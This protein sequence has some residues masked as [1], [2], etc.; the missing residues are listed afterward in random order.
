MNEN[1]YCVYMHTNKVNGK[2]YIG[3]TR[4]N[5]K[6]RWA[7][8]QG[9]KTQP[10]YRAIEKYG[11]DSFKH[12]ILY[13]EL[14]YKSACEYEINLIK[15]Y[16]TTDSKYGYNVSDGGED[17]IRYYNNL[18]H[19]NKTVYQY[20]FFGYYIQKF[21]S[22]IEAVKY[23]NIENIH[24]STNISSC[25]RKNGKSKSA[26][27]FIWSY[28][29][30]GEKINEYNLKDAYG[31][32][33]RIK[34]YQYGLDGKYI[35]MFE[36]INSVANT[37]NVKQQSISAAIDL[38]HR[39]SCGFQWRTYLKEEGIEPYTKNPDRGNKLKKKIVRISKYD[40][41]VTIY[42]GIVDAKIEMN[43]QDTSVISDVLNKNRPSAYGYFWFYYSEYESGEWQNQIDYTRMQRPIYVY[44]KQYNEFI[45]DSLKELC[46]RSKEDFNI[47]F[48]KSC[49]CEV[50]NGNSSNHKGFIFS[51]DK[52][53][54]DEIVNKFLPKEKN[55]GRKK[56]FVYTLNHM[57]CGSYN[58]LKELCDNS[59][60]DFG[61][62]FNMGNVSNVCSG[63]TK[64]YKGY[65]FSYVPLFSENQN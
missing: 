38:P 12:D 25:A 29:Y 3:I 52:L 11:W 20:S 44:D 48:S 36:S 28:E 23:L 65:I 50:C 19:M 2:K 35:K 59:L 46:D 27:G 1:N 57:Y 24:A 64:Q 18:V 43:L 47:I 51:Y 5:P 55:V 9:Y 54:Y 17:V 26:Y 14:D 31:E 13:K 30:L 56:T 34:V 10:F 21:D 4:Q 22:I 15:K 7:N 39:K 16:N 41:S 62:K 40:L 45:Y 63:K 60:Q 32:V 53:S 37:F 8:G 61:I 6:I 49:I 33:N 58:S 42:D